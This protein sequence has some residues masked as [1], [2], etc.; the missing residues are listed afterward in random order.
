MNELGMSSI[1]LLIATMLVAVIFSWINY[2]LTKWGLD[3]K[4]NKWSL[5]RKALY[6]IGAG[7]IVWVSAMIMEIEVLPCIAFAIVGGYFAEK[8]ISIYMSKREKQL[9][10]LVEPAVRVEEKPKTVSPEVKEVAPK[11]ESKKKAC[12]GLR[13][14]TNVV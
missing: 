4:P 13:K 5:R 10:A 8:L 11:K 3:K 12:K 2:A 14:K 1:W 7:I 6:G 9:E